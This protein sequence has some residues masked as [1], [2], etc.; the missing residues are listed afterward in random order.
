M[1]DN[2]R[3][4]TETPAD[5][6]F[7]FDDHE[8]DWHDGTFWFVGWSSCWSTYFAER[9]YD[10]DLLDAEDDSAFRTCPGPES[11]MFA[12]LDVIETAMGEALPTAVRDHL[13]GLR[14]PPDDAAK[15]AWCQPPT[16]ECHHLRP[17]GTI[18]TSHA[19]PW[20]DDPHDPTRNR[21]R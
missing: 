8:I 17:D 16:M 2:A 20:S 3:T 10:E 14:R 5:V 12:S 6:S 1:T 19:P 13:D 15:A 9:V 11:G 21:G 7:L 18:V 4:E